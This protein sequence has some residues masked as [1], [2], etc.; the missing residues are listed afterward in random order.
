ML[1]NF[2]K[3]SGCGN[4]FILFDNQTSKLPPLTPTLIQKLCARQKGI[5]ADG[6]ILLEAS[7][8]A[9]Y[10]MRI[11]NA[12]GSEAEMCGNGIRCLFKFIQECGIQ[13][14]WLNIE[15]LFSTLKV[16]SEDEDVA[17]QMGSPS[18]IRWSLNLFPWTIHYLDTGVPH[19][20]IFTEKLDLLDLNECGRTLRFHPLFA[21]RGANVN[22]VQIDDQ[23][24][25]HVRTYERGVEQ[26][27]LACGTGAT[28]AALAAA[29]LY[30]LKGPLTVKVRSEDF[31]RIDFEYNKGCFTKVRMI[32]PA[33][34]AF[35]GTVNLEHALE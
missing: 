1:F 9:H 19:A 13:E 22:F 27:T 21:P 24:I 8:K 33:K 5:G 31:L 15:T 4:D 30:E 26:E 25:L 6:V 16:S 3:Y 18:E 10:K 7:Q 28:A 14:K 17:V 32:G 20:V 34:L 23:G 35:K 29:K 11:F 12:D 2:S